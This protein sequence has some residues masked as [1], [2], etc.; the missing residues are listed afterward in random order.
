MG[1]EGGVEGFL[2]LWSS[3]SLNISHMRKITA[4]E[5]MVGRT[6]RNERQS[7]GYSAGEDKF[8][9]NKQNKQDNKTFFQAH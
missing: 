2:I 9:G 8:V 1:C 5:E 3:T 4:E 7:G 6:V